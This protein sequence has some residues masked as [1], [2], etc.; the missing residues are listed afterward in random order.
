MA[1]QAHHL[2]QPSNPAAFPNQLP[3][4]QGPGIPNYNYGQFLQP[5]SGLP[6]PQ[7]PLTQQQSLMAFYQ[8]LPQIDKYPGDTAAIL[9]LHRQERKRI[10]D[11][12]EKRAEQ[13]RKLAY[14]QNQDFKKLQE[15][16]QEIIVS[17]NGL[18]TDPF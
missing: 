14:L 13:I 3:P 5:N 12:T 15:V 8:G 16:E 9:K 17:K 11:R 10:M 7:P 1:S 18:L 4:T 2:F 6:L